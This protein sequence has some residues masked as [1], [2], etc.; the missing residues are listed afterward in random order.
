MKRL[1][2]MFALCLLLLTSR[3]AAA[4]TADKYTAKSAIVMERTS[5]RVLFALNERQKLPMAST[6]KIVTALTVIENCDLSQKVTVPKEACGV[7]G[8][9]VYL[10]EGE[11]LT[12]EQLLYGLML[13]SGN[14]CA[15]ALAVHCGGSAENFCR[16]MHQTAQKY[17]CKDSS[18][19]NP[20]GLPAE[21]HYTTAWDLAKIT[22]AALDNQVFAKIV[23]SRRAAFENRSFVNKNKLLFSF[24]G[25]DGVKTGYTKKAGRCLVASATRQGMQLVAVALNCAP[26]YEECA[27]M[28][29]N[30]FAKYNLKTVLPANKLCGAVYRNGKPTYYYCTQPFRYPLAQGEKPTVKV[31]LQEDVQRAEVFLDGKKVYSASLQAR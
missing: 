14:D 5:G 20:H 11:V 31:T 23:S 16:L 8:S 10:K 21:G 25:C 13:R 24:E 27:R 15:V 6:T 26:M 18:F 12:V 30:A 19:R 22:C 7:E 1:F 2:T 17:G 29:E 9:S 4:L 3:G 28:L